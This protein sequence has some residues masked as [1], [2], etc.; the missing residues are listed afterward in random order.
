MNPERL[1]YILKRFVL[2]V[3][4][5]IAVATFV[6][7][8]LRSA[9][10]DY[11]TLYHGPQMTAEASEHVA[12]SFGLNRPVHEQYILYITNVLTGNLGRSFVSSEPVFSILLSKALNTVV[13]TVTAQILAF[14]LG[15][16]IGAYFA[17]RRGTTIDNIGS[18]LVLVTYA[19]PVFWV[20]MLGIMFFSFHLNWLPTGGMHSATFEINSFWDLYFN[21]DFVK[22]LI[23]PL[24]VTAAYWITIPTLVMR[25]NMIELFGADFIKM[26]HAE[27]LSK[28]RVLYRH[29]ARN[30]LLPI[31]HY[32]ALA[33]A[34][35]FG[36]SVIIETVFSW[37]G[38]GRAMWAAVGN[39]D[40]PLAQGAFLM[41]A[42]LVITAN[43]LVDI[44]SVY[45][46][47][48]A[49]ETR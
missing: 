4:T 20:G 22:H 23:L 13:L 1:N 33:L 48:R 8:L 43:F 30:A 17:Y 40:T 37:P 35:A 21:W 36:G 10:G 16:I 27:G 11:S 5:F 2:M 3:F 18:G 7:I 32:S 28:R 15:P 47:P 42:A 9:P 14:T 45:I 25:S 24:S 49:T 26:K 44:L 39:Q 41:L 46:D 12:E 19:A 34:F 6:F 29:T 31:A 38:V